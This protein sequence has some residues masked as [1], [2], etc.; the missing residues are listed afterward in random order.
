MTLARR[1]LTR[2]GFALRI[3]A[4]GAC[5]ASL[6]SVRARAVAEPPVGRYR[7]TVLR[8]GRPIGAHIRTLRQNGD[9]LAVTTE[10]DLVVTLF[11]VPLYSYRHTSVERWRGDTLVGLDSQTRKNGKEK[12]LQGVRDGDGPL[13]LE[14]HKGERRTFPESPLTTTLWHPRTPQAPQL[15]EVEDGWMKTNTTQDIGREAVRIGDTRQTA[16]HYRLAGEVQRDVW[17]D[18][19]GLLLRVA[20]QH[21]DGSRIVMQPAADFT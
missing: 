6:G 16:R 5:L 10:I 19:R 13:V 17:Y 11:S 9:I 12:R 4:V 8:E 2:R 15:L 18:D 20:F 3:G 21:D 14:N 1:G 7:Y